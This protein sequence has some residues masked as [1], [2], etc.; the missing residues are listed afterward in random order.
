MKSYYEFSIGSGLDIQNVDE[1]QLQKKTITTGSK[2]VGK[3]PSGNY[4]VLE[5]F[6]SKWRKVIEGSLLLQ[7]EFM[8]HNVKT[9]QRNN[10]LIL[11]PPLQNYDST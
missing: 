2:I 9:L 6:K 5:D 11:K 3:Q 4:P 8:T 7:G 1:E 10:A